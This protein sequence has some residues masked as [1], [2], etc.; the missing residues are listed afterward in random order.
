[1]KILLVLSGIFFL[2][3]G[4]LLNKYYSFGYC[5]WDLAFFT[6][7]S[8]KLIRGEQYVPVVGIN[9]FGDHSY[10]IQ[11][12]ILPF[13]YFFQS[14]LTLIYIK[15]IAFIGS[16]YLVYRI[17][18]SELNERWGYLL[19]F[20]YII[21]PGN[22]FGLMYE[23]N[24]ESLAPPIIFLMFMA[25]R[26][27]DLCRLLIWSVFLVLIKE[28]MFLVAILFWVRFILVSKESKRLIA[29]FVILVLLSVFIFLVVFVIPHYRGL[30]YHAFLVRYEFSS[31]IGD[32]FLSPFFHSREFFSRIFS[33][34]SFIYI[35]NV[36]SYML[37]LALFSPSALLLMIPLLFQHLLSNRSPEHSIY[38][39]YVPTM[40]PFI[41]VAAIETILLIKKALPS[42]AIQMRVQ[43]YFLAIILLTTAFFFQN[44]TVYLNS[45]K[46]NDAG[47]IWEMISRIPPNEPLLATFEFLAP[48]STR[49]E[50]YSFHMVCSDIF[51][52]MDLMG[53]YELNKNRNFV[54]PSSVHYAILNLKDDW[55]QKT[56]ALGSRKEKERINTFLSDSQ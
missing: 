21:F 48:L 15:L 41:F 31:N 52:D 7:A 36:F 22:I 27:M 42:K 1:M 39:H 40:A 2:F 44:C 33:Y 51:Q 45:S 35:A 10:F 23:Y 56:M 38:Y 49:P 6:Q 18:A 25:L 5:D 12:I 19:L 47:K 28:N 16:A 32:L 3:L 29:A 14:P 34:S 54:L 53:L 13:F 24:T 26:R 50:I 30:S 9:F 20:A 43:M 37:P 4:Q 17:A 46:S 8:W 55:V 11:F